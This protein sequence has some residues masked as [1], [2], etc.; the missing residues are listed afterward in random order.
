M[1]VLLKVQRGEGS[2]SVVVE[3]L[4]GHKKTQQQSSAVLSSNCRAPEVEKPDPMGLPKGR[5]L[6]CDVR[7]QSWH[8][9][10]ARGPLHLS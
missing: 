1:A 7:W 4:S 10:L 3:A 8:Q 2:S 6:L 9:Q 5:E